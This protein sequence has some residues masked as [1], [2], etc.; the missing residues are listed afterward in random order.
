MT[1]TA[2]TRASHHAT[3]MRGDVRWGGWRNFARYGGQTRVDELVSRASARQRDVFGFP[4]PG[5]P[6]WTKRTLDEVEARYPDADWS[7]Y[8]AAL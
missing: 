4:R 2:G 1:A 7:R 5:D 6:Y 8:R 3:L